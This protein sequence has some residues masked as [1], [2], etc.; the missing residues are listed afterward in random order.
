MPSTVNTGDLLLIAYGGIAPKTYT[1]PIGWTVLDSGGRRRTYVK[2]ADGT[3]GGTTVD[4]VSTVGE[5][6]AAQAIRISSWEGT[7]ASVEIGTNATGLSTNPDPPSLTA[8]WGAEDN[9]W[10]AISTGYDD[11]ADYTIAPTN[12]LGLTSTK[13][14]A[15]FNASA[16]VGSSYR[17]LNAA[18][19]NPS[20]YT[21]STGEAWNANTIVVRP[22]S[23][24]ATAYTIEAETGSI[25]ATGHA[26]DLTVSKKIN[27]VLGNILVSG[28]NVIQK[29]SRNLSGDTGNIIADGKT[30]DL[31]RGYNLPAETGNIIATG[32]SITLQKATIIIADTGNIIVTGYDANLGN[33]KNYVLSAETGSIVVDGKDI[34]LL[35]ESGVTADPGNIAV[36]GHEVNLVYSGDNRV[37]Y[38]VLVTDGDLITEFATLGDLC[39][40]LDLP[41]DMTTILR[42]K[43]DIA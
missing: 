39:T 31:T 21:L 2:V 43:G 40:E 35:R 11:D 37:Y 34:N 33:Q 12:Y 41:A 5:N 10:L 30:I 27:S 23:G 13:T 22:Q 19:E 38:K 3:E 8:S 1:D 18:T 26:I 32:Y 42:T 4:I 20:T 17:Q 28:K 9:L 6:A 7:L 25:A 36:T 14:G 29:I 24:G 16:E 15:G